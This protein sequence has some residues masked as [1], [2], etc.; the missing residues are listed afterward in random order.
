MKK[1]I[2][3]EAAHCFWNAKG[4]QLETCRDL[5][6]VFLHSRSFTESVENLTWALKRST[7]DIAQESLDVCEAIIAVLENKGTDMRSRL[8]M[9]ADNAAELVLR[10]YRESTDADFRSRCLDL[11]D[12]LLSMQAYG[13]TKELE[14]YER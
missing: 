1:E 3:D 4:R 9:E 14:A 8:Y 7:A 11:V 5:I 12:R 13:I 6:A 2:R 10:A